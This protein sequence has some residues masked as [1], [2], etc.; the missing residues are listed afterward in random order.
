VDLLVAH[1]QEGVGR[2]PWWGQF[3]EQFFVAPGS[4]LCE[5]VY[6]GDSSRCE[7]GKGIV[8]HSQPYINRRKGVIEL[9]KHASR[10]RNNTG[11][12]ELATT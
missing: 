5:M 12:S 1:F 9:A 4:G 8:E 7:K 3:L 6:V 10:T 11:I 2:D